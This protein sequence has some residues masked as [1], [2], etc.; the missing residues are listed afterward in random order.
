M[1]LRQTLLLTPLLLPLA[2]CPLTVEPT[3]GTPPPS[4]FIAGSVRLAGPDGLEEPGGPTYVFRYDCADPPPPVGTGRPVDFLV[5]PDDS[6]TSGEAAFVFPSVPASTCALLT[7]FVDKDR[8]FS[9]FVSIGNQ[10]TA[11]DLATNAATVSVEAAIAGSDLIPPVEDVLLEATIVVPLDRPAFTITD[12]T[13]EPGGRLDVGPAVGTTPNS[14]VRLETRSVDSRLTDVDA[15]VFTVV[16]EADSDGNGWP[17]DLNADGAPDVRWPRVLFVRVDDTDATGMTQAEGPIV[18]PGVVLPLDTNDAFDVQTNLLLASKLADLPFDGEQVLPQTA[19]TVVVPPLIVTDLATRTTAPIEQLRDTGANVL[20]DYQIVVMNSTGQ[21]WTVPNEL[22]ATDADQASLFTADAPAEPLPPTT[23]V[24]GTV[25][26]TAEP[27]GDALVTMFDCAAPPPPAGTG[28]PIALSVIKED[29]FVGGVGSFAFG[30]VPADACVIIAGYVDRDRDFDPFHSITKLPTLGDLL[31]SSEI[32]TVGPAGDDGLVAPIVDVALVE[33]V[34]VPLEHPAF[35]VREYAD[36]PPTM[37]RAAELGATET[38]FMNLDATSHASPFTNA[39]DPLFTLVFAPDAD[40]DGMADDNNGDSVPDVL[41]PR[42]LLLRIDPDDASGLTSAAGPTVLPG[43]VLPLDPG[44]PTN[45]TTNLALAWSLQ[46]LPFDGASVFPQASLRVAVP[47][48]IVTDLATASTS[49]IEAVA[50]AGVA[51]DGE[52]R[53]IVMNSTG[54]TWQIPNESQLFDVAG[55]NARF[56]VTPPVVDAPP[57]GSVTGS[58]ATADGSEPGGSTILFRFDCADPPP[59]EGAGRPLDFTILPASAWSGGSVDYFFGGLEPSTCQLLTGFIDRDDDWSGLY[60]TANQATSGDFAI[61]P[62]VVT[63][64]DVDETSGL[65]PDLVGQDLVA[66]LTVPLERPVFTMVSPAGA[67]V[68]PTMTVGASPGTTESVF[69]ELD[70]ADADSPLCSATSPLF[71]LVFAPDLDGDGAPDDFNGDG[72]PDV[73]WPR[74]LARKLSGDDVAGIAVDEVSPIVLPGI[75]VPLD[76]ADPFNPATNLVIQAAQAGVPFDGASV[77]P[78]TSLT[79]AVPG[80]VL[81]DLATLTVAPIE[82]VALSTNVLGEY[83]ILLMNSSGQTWQLPN[84]LA[85]YGEA[86]QGAVFVVE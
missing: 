40:G 76:P 57:L 80:L 79:V 39:E 75:I 65:V 2:G 67:L 74:V 14:Y 77:F 70:A 25:T 31:L 9:P 8:D 60:S 44:D 41:W 21:T 37:S 52:Y 66:G 29:S 69:V 84:E 42:V 20:G 12:L 26:L 36:E 16:L 34:E 61:G 53:I 6:Y 5:L 4:T 56:T 47:G 63:V 19:I 48:V 24:A 72:L 27:G 43:V 13:G 73:L 68:V 38:V 54:Q 83:Q 55:Q 18:L 7:G 30:T 22:Q 62:L 50:A 15:P 78:Q 71:T 46:G 59:P 23:L 32:I 81:T 1:R 28:S 85:L 11:G 35:T 51:V 64:P 86:G 10:V 33:G 3:D 58:I 49:P 45:P 17:D 82:T